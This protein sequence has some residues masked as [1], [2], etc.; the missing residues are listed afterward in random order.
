MVVQPSSHAETSSCNTRRTLNKVTYTCQD[1][2]RRC[3]GMS[4]SPDSPVFKFIKTKVFCKTKI[5]KKKRTKGLHELQQVRPTISWEASKL[6]M[7]PQFLKRP[8]LLYNSQFL[9]ALKLLRGPLFL[10]RALRGSLLPEGPLSSS[11]APYFSR[12][13]QAHEGT[14]VPEGPSLSWGAP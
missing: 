9:G 8:K 7:G 2:C 14:Q 6:L 5:T 10:E 4:H 13:P 1:E 3:S 11:K 12:G